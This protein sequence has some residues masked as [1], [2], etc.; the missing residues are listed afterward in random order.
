MTLQPTHQ[1]AAMLGFPTPDELAAIESQVERYARS[2]LLPSAIRG[3]APDVFTVLMVARDLGLPATSGLFKVH[4]VEGKPTLAADLM[5]ALGLSQGHDIWL[6]ESTTE[7]ATYAGKRRGSGREQSITYTIE[8]AKTAGLTGKANWKNDPAAMLRARASS[9]LCRVLIPDVLGGIGAS[10]EEA[11]DFVSPA[12]PAPVSADEAAARL[13][14]ANPAVAADVV[15]GQVVADEVAPDSTTA[16]TSEV[17]SVAAA[18][19]GD[20]ASAESVD[21]LQDI[22]RNAQADGVL[23]HPV[24]GPTTLREVITGL[25]DQ[26]RQAQ[27]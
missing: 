3:K 20:A 22:W 18:Y 16:P 1:P 4:V 12:A 10:T 6:V 21:A 15:D 25:V 27:Q 11:E 23:D 13:R 7:R 26:V 2:N 9:Q 14:A 24:D 5:V 17:D 8:Q 19:L